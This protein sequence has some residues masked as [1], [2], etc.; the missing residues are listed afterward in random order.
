MLEGI[1]WSFWGH[2][3]KTTPSTGKIEP[4]SGKEALC[5]TCLDLVRDLG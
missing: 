2:H 4:K 3:G 5:L 1:M